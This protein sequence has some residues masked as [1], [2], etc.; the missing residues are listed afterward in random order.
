MEQVRLSARELA[1]FLLRSG[2]IDSRFAGFNRAQEG[3]RIHRQL[4][5]AYKKE[6]GSDYKSEVF[7]KAER[8]VSGVPYQIEGRADGIFTDT[9][10]VRTIDE[11]KTTAGQIAPDSHPEHWAQAKIYAAILCE[12]ESLLQVRVRLTYFQVDEEETVPFQEDLTAEQAETYLCDLLEQYA[13]WAKR[14][15]AWRE[16][17]KASLSELAFPFP[18]YRPGQRAM[19]GEI[20]RTFRDRK[21]LL[22]QA[23]TGIG[24]SMSTIFPALKAIGAGF[25]DKVFYLTARGTTAAAAENA[26]RILR[27]ASA[28]K[29]RCITLTAK[30]KLCFLDERN[31][32]PEAC[33]Y[34][35]G[36]Y[37]RLRQGLH[38]ALE[39]ENYTR[40]DIERLAKELTL[41]PFEF[42]LD[43]SLWCDLLIGDYNYLFDPV[44]SLKRYFE[45]NGEYLFLVDEAHNLP[46]RAR[47]MYS[48]ALFLSQFQ[49]TARVLGR[50]KSRL[51]TLIKEAANGL[52][53][54]RILCMREENHTFFQEMPPE[55][56]TKSLLKLAQP[57]Q[58]YLDE[59]K[60]GEEHDA[61]LELYFAVQDFLRVVDG[62]DS[63]YTT[64][65]S[66]W[67][68]EAEIS[69][70]CLD[71]SDF[72]A[73]SFALGRASVLFS[74][75]LSPPDYY[76]N[77]LGCGEARCIAL[78]SPFPRE[79]LG[80][81]IVRG[82]STRYKDREQSAALVAEYLYA[83]V[84]SKVG[85]YIAYFP[86]Y[87]YLDMILELFESAHPEVRTLVQQAGMNDA[88]RDSFL[89]EFSE[90]PTETLL[91]FGVLGGV[92]G[93]GIDLTGSRLIGTAIV[94]VGL[95]MVSPR[96][97]KLR[98][99]YEEV[100]GSGFEY[101]YRY[102]GMNKV[103]Q[104]AGRVIRTDTDR[105]I[106][107]LIDDRYL[108]MDYRRLCPPHWDGAQIVRSPEELTRQAVAGRFLP[109]RRGNTPQ[110]D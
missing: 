109:T 34:A 48:T 15:Q 53:E 84:R 85:N 28:P 13:P 46:S 72:L 74:A 79:N 29:L 39:E 37:T 42:Q 49:E 75:T 22:C 91:G 69:L 78:P 64:Q 54:M 86:S 103:L 67:G 10:G 71:P 96:Q 56:L 106:V 102:P 24:K 36:Y 110:D 88:A 21:I 18:Q 3:S 20:F 101:A 27:E 92:F 70:L 33:P 35:D 100:F 51:K 87:A 44:V 40:A 8:M 32:T 65:C 2:S 17:R 6:E 19:A 90:S 52:E 4:Q 82:V 105:G 95:P 58:E 30:D 57:M 81:Y 76:R 50:K 94:G 104:A 99:Y 16:E 26:V 108:T 62:Y 47:D 55:S 73:G 59:H 83:M 60:E 31:C 93:E 41:C 14:E 25:G 23:P 38:R 5:S 1:E 97:E 80:L 66:A 98:E 61:V 89:A 63:H 68:K 12:T 43:L 107:L 7:L 11:I 45:G 9:D 77:V